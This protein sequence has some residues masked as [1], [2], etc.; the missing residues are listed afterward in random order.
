MSGE[1]SAAWMCTN[2][3]EVHD[4]WQPIELSRDNPKIVLNGIPVYCV[5]LSMVWALLERSK[6]TT[7]IRANQFGAGLVIAGFVIANPQSLTFATSLALQCSTSGRGA[8][9]VVSKFCGNDVNLLPKLC[10]TINRTSIK[11]KH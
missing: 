3:Y 7:A 5:Y 1:L 10:Q 6:N 8:A 2:P 9:E 11:G 4:P